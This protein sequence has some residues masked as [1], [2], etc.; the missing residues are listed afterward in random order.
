MAFSY[1]RR[2]DQPNIYLMAG[3]CDFS[4][5]FDDAVYEQIEE[6]LPENAVDEQHVSPL[7]TLEEQTALLSA[8]ERADLAV[9]AMAI[10][11][12]LEKDPADTEAVIILIEALPDT[13]FANLKQA[14]LATLV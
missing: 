12:L 8:A 7:T 3:Y 6:P 13:P 11:N 4:G 5:Q 14:V 9:S 10:K 1:V 2:K